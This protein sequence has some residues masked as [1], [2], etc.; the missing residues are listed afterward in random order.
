MLLFVLMVGAR[1]VFLVFLVEGFGIKVP[2]L[3]KQ[4]PGWSHERPFLRQLQRPCM[5]PVVHAQHGFFLV[6]FVFFAVNVSDMGSS[7][8]L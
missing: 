8:S 1:V 5:Q 3:L 2:S 6:S 4:V 7:V